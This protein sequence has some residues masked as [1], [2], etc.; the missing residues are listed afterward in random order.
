MDLGAMGNRTVFKEEPL[1]KA[2]ILMMKDMRHMIWIS[3]GMMTFKVQLK[4]MM[5]MKTKKN[6]MIDRR[7][8]TIKKM[9]VKMLN[10][11]VNQD[12]KIRILMLMMLTFRTSRASTLTMIQTQ[13][14]PALK[15]VPISSILT[16]ARE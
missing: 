16:Y 9:E 7:N 5:T 13:S 12:N 11:G 2:I 1:L 14:T 8:K 6:R 4:G 15:Q 10:M 3:L